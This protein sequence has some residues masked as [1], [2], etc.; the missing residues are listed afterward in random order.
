MTDQNKPPLKILRRDQ[1]EERTGLSRSTIYERVKSGT[2]P[3]PISLGAKAV[4][5]LESEVDRWIT[6]RIQ[7]SRNV[8]S[9]TTVKV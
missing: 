4:G 2:F 5:W 1:V 7:A 3:A 9:K 8:S 6:D